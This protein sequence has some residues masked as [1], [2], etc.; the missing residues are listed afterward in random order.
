MLV[1]AQGKR[2]FSYDRSGGEELK[3][4]VHNEFKNITLH[5][6]FARIGCKTLPCV[7]E[8][9]VFCCLCSKACRQQ[10]V[11]DERLTGVHMQAGMLRLQSGRR[12]KPRL[13]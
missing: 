3:L 10:L 11:A 4:D 6:A 9:Q 12:V 8:K 1:C 7:P 13:V 5:N 2:V